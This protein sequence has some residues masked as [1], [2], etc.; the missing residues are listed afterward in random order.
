MDERETGKEIPE[1]PRGGAERG[2][3]R[4]QGRGVKRET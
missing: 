4:E 2:E 3:R 1:P